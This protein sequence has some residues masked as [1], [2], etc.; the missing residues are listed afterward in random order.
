MTST[1]NVTSSS[2][3]SRSQGS[4]NIAAFLNYAESAQNYVGVCDVSS[5]VN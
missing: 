4:M 2:A 3:G 1:L 5:N